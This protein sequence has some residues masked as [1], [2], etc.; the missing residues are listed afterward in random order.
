MSKRRLFRARRPQNR[1][2][3][4]DSTK[5]VKVPD[6]VSNACTGKIEGNT[7]VYRIEIP[8]RMPSLNEYIDC[9]RKNKYIAAQLKSEKQYYCGLWIR[10]QLPGVHIEAPVYMRY[11][12]YEPNRRRDKSNVS[13]YGRKIIEDALVERGVLKD[14]GWDEIVGFSDEFDVDKTNPRIEVEI[15]ECLDITINGAAKPTGKD[16]PASP[17]HGTTTNT[18][19]M[20]SAAQDTG[21][22]AASPE[23]RARTTSRNQKTL[24]RK[25]QTRKRSR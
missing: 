21:D 5:N 20:S 22:G 9:E 1:T 3:A 24:L 11:H 23:R 18:K 2:E 15:I 17:V 14:D 12:W 16:A 8:G 10:K 13:S 25:T 6:E 7:T 4:N 19:A